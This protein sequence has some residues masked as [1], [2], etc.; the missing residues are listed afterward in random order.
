MHPDLVDA[1]PWHTTTLLTAQEK[2]T[3]A[4][5]LARRAHSSS[6]SASRR[7]LEASGSPHPSLLKREHAFMADLRTTRAAMASSGGGSAGA[8]GGAAA[9]AAPATGPGALLSRSVSDVL[10]RSGMRLAEDASGGL[11]VAGGGGG[12]GSDPSDIGV[13]LGRPDVATGGSHMVRRYKHEGVWGPLRCEGGTSYAWSCCGNS[14]ERSRGCA[15]YT[16]AHDRYC[17]LSF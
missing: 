11:S 12:A 17:F 8:A 10:K 14:D 7:I 1:P 16:V 2:R 4:E 3:A 13:T 6:R 9:A 5:A 15:S